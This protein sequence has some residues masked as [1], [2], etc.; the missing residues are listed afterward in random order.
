[1]GSVGNPKAIAGRFFIAIALMAVSLGSPAQT[2]AQGGVSGNEASDEDETLGELVVTGTRRSDRTVENSPTPI[3]VISGDSLLQQGFSSLNDALRTEVVSLNVQRFVAQ[4]GAAFI[5]PFSLRGLPSDQTLVLVNGKRQH[6]SALVQITNQPLSAGAQGPDLATIP[7]IA[8]KQIEVLRDGAAA[9]YGSDAIAGVINFRLQDAN[10]GFTFITRAGRYYEDD[11]DDLDVQVNAGFPLTAQGFFNLSAEYATSEPTSR[12][13]QRPDAQALIDAG[14]TAVPVP[15]QV[16]GNVDTEAVRVFFNAEVPTTESMAAYAFGNYSSSEGES[17]FFYRNPTTRLDVFRSVPLTNQPGGP[18]FSFT[19]QFPGGFAPDFGTDITDLS[20]T[21][22]FR[23][24][25][26]VG[27]RYDVSAGTGRSELEY[28]LSNTVNPSLGPASPTTFEP[29]TIEQLET[30][31][32]VDFVYPWETSWFASPLSIAYGAEV[33]EEKFEI[34]AGD[35]ASWEAGPFARVFDP[36]TGTFV[37]LAVGSSGFPGY[38]P[39]TAGEFSRSNWAVYTDVETDVTERLTFGIA[40]RYEDFSDFGDTFNWKVSGRFA[41][42]DAVAL[43]A[44]VNTGFRAPTP[45]QSNISDVATNIDPLTGGLLLVATLP[46]TNAISQFYGARALSPEESFNVAG[47]L[48]FNFL[49][50][51]LTVDYFDIEVDDR[52]GLTS[53]ITITAADRAALLAQGVDPGQFQSV[54]FLG[55]FFD[56]RTRGV[57]VVLAKT[58]SFDAGSELGLTLGANRTRNEAENIRN[59]LAVSREREIEIRE[60]NPEIRGNVSLDYRLGRWGLLV[61]GNYYGEWTDAV[62]NATPTPVSFDQTFPEEW[63]VDVETSFDVTDSLTL[64]LGAENVFDVYP[65]ED[66]RLSQ[67]NNGIVYPQFSPF[68]FSGGFYYLRATAKF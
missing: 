40:A 22:G 35:R 21:A 54:R 68:G 29:G 42:S 23:G 62:A 1:M 30:R 34:Q 53:R 47:G 26:G 38:T 51:L 32:N 15:A 59:V 41:F 24:E 48:V 11:G 4:D 50:Y 18:R 63:L 31:A 66:L 19:S 27:L 9:Q 7:A 6:R 45:G 37:G 49:G 3:D 20:V 44:S 12:G 36:D 61:R 33:R 43:R 25:F 46:P 39:E 14:N 2:A 28:S 56:S 57:D 60:F 5:R 67:I 8:V 64:T 10:E 17:P 13:R 65:A 55:N 58:W 52:L 16:W